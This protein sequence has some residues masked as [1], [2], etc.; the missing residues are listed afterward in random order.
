MKKNFRSTFFLFAATLL[1]YIIFLVIDYEKKY[2]LVI[3][4]SVP[5]GMFIG[6]LIKFRKNLSQD[7]MFNGVLF[8]LLGM[9][10]AISAF[11]FNDNIYVNLLMALSLI[12]YL[13]YITFHLIKLEITE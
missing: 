1:I 13:Y 7:I 12:I 10:F 4:S 3:P 5:Y 8:S 11:I 9:I 6:Y 2:L